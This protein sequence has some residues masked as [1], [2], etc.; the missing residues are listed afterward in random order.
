MCSKHILRFHIYASHF[1]ALALHQHLKGVS[2]RVPSFLLLSLV[3]RVLHHC[4]FHVF[5]SCTLDSASL[6]LALCTFKTSAHCC[7]SIARTA[8]GAF[9]HCSGVVA[10]VFLLIPTS[11]IRNDGVCIFPISLQFCRSIASVYYLAVT[12]PVDQKR[13]RNTMVV[14]C[15][16]Y[17]C[18]CKGC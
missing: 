4:L 18:L 8:I 6:C 1:L 17:R 13:I 16:I 5:S 2:H 3:C 15:P 12:R 9:L 7:V 14:Q 10:F 11:R